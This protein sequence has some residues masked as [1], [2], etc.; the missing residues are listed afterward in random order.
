M[1]KIL[2]IISSLLLTTQ[3]SFAQSAPNY[4]VQSN[5]N[6][7]LMYFGDHKISNKWGVHLEAQFRRN[8]YFSK[9]QQL[10]L[11]TGVNYHINPNT[12]ATAGY[13]YVHTAPY[14]VF[15]VKL[16]F[17]EHRFWEQLQT[18]NQVGRFELVNRLRMEQ[19]FS[20][21]PVYDSAISAYEVG[22][23]VYTNRGRLLN[24]AS[25]PLNHKTMADNTLYVSVYDEMFVNFGKNIGKN[26]FDQ[27]RAYAA[28]GYKLPIYGKIELGYMKQTILKSD[29]VKVENNRT[30]QLG[31]YSTLNFFK[32]K[33]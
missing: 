1:K 7:W 18:K 4:N 23:A 10:L 27:N 16:A 26:M 21:L 17:P 9:T 31:F 5:N 29:G 32:T 25:L 3:Y 30:L 20:Q 19:R 13:C 22:D 11:R 28:L 15:P 14:G 33:K 8:D 6:A 24:R 2:L 12:F